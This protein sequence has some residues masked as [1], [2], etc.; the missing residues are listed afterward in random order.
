MSNQDCTPSAKYMVIDGSVFACPKAFGHGVV[1]GLL[2][3][4]VEG[5]V[6]IDHPS[7]VNVMSQFVNDNAFR[8]V[9]IARIA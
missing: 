9:R 5:V 3:T 7:Q 1:V 8:A 4:A 6:D 2:K